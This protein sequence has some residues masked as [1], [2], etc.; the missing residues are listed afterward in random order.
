MSADT[1]WLAEGRIGG[2]EVLVS[3]D[4]ATFTKSVAKGTWGDNSDAKTVTWPQEAGVTAVRLRCISEATAVKHNICN[5]AEVNIIGEY[6]AG[7]GTPPPTTPPPTTPPPTIPPPAGATLDQADWDVTASSQQNSPAEVALAASAADG[8]VGTW[9]L[10]QYD[11]N[12]VQLPQYIQF[13]WPAKTASVTGLVYQ[14]RQATADTPWLADGR[15]GG[16]E[17]L[18]STDGATFTK[19]VAQGTWADSSAAKTVTWPEE[20]GV[21]GVRLRCLSE[22]DKR[23]NI[24]NAAEVN[25]LGAYGAAPPPT[26]AGNALPR[27]GW[28]AVPDS[29]Q[30]RDGEFWPGKF[31]LDGIQ[32]NM[33]HTQW[34]GDKTRP[35]FTPN[36]DTLPHKIDIIMGGQTNS[37][38]G[39]KYLPRQGALR[40]SRLPGAGAACASNL[41]LSC[42]SAVRLQCFIVLCCFLINRGVLSRLCHACDNVAC[43]TCAQSVPSWMSILC[44]QMEASKAFVASTRFVSART[45]RCMPKVAA[46]IE[47]HCRDCCIHAG[48]A[49]CDRGKRCFHAS[50]L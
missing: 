9:W 40:C 28:S 21:V 24:C 18:I 6:G 35:Q 16:Y 27:A 20:K 44:L 10:T 41:S 46:C 13:M 32:T 1:P 4:G 19:T 3:T 43:S 26:P 34:I 48:A 45:V 12:G 25:I 29:Q 23:G 38:S 49:V 42:N 11:P 14:P 17:V 22:A 36:F 50:N 47:M 15:I 33:W 2:Y 39:L 5:A 37:V 30:V 31:V 8:K 7:T